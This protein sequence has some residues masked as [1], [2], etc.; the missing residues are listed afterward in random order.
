[1]WL[2]SQT[3]LIHW[4]PIN[5]TPFPSQ[6][7]AFNPDDFDQASLQSTQM[8]KATVISKKKA[9]LEINF[10][11][12]GGGALMRYLMKSLFYKSLTLQ[13]VIVADVDGKFCRTVIPPV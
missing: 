11:G 9:V 3:E 8:L 2:F 6:V 1:M 5:L 12:E 10:V 13:V 7:P 4:L